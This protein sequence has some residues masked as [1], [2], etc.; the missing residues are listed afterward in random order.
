[1][2]ASPQHPLVLV[3]RPREQAAATVQSLQQRGVRVA[4]FP[5]IEITPVEVTGALRERFSQLN[6]YQ[7]LIFI[8][9]NAV[10]G[11][12]AMLQ[13]LKIAPP[14]LEM[15]IACIGRASTEAARQ[16]GFPVS[17]QAEQGFNSE[18]LL[19]LQALQQVRGRKILIIRGQGGR[20]KLADTLRQR[21]AEVDYA[22]VYRRGVPRQDGEISRR[23]LSRDWQDMQIDGITVT[24]NESLQNL[25][26]MLEPPGKKAMLKTP[27]IVPSRRCQDLAQSLGFESVILAESAD[28]QHMVAAVMHQL[29]ASQDK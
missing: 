7:L 24:S 19:D 17:L 10:H 8:S 13:Q 4:L 22:E 18:A 11:A 26:D 2:P 3:T 14:S 29:H 9:A 25:Y 15:D 27:L 21:G 23:Q 12:R 28:N 1:M 5:T 6:H 16:A 20:E